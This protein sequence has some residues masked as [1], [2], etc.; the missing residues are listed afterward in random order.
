MQD[1]IKNIAAH[2][3]CTCAAM[4]MTPL[5]Q[6]AF[7]AIGRQLIARANYVEF[8]DFLPTISH[9]RTAR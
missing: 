1:N 9:L 3:Q 6:H 5:R 4:L 2:N 8:S 7:L